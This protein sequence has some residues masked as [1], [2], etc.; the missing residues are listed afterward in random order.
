VSDDDDEIKPPPD[1][2]R[3]YFRALGKRYGAEG[4]KAR[5]E[6]MSAARLSQQARKAGKQ[7]GKNLTPEQR[8]ER[9]KKAAAARWKKK[10]E[11]DA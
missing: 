10:P 11:E 3:E 4:G 7:S 8:R 2:V 6:K 9:A 5:A 1:E